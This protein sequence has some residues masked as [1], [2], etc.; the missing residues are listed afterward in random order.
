MHLTLPAS[1]VWIGDTWNGSVVTSVANAVDPT[2]IMISVTGAREGDA[3]LTR[4]VRR[5]TWIVV[6]RGS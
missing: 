4:S 1:Q 5:D 6:D 2:H 3:H